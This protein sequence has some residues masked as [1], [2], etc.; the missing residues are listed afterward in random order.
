MGRHLEGRTPVAGHMLVMDTIYEGGYKVNPFLV[1][2]V[3]RDAY[4]C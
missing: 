1:L 4:F 3:S 2:I